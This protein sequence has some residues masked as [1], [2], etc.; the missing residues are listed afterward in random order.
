MLMSSIG[1]GFLLGTLLGVVKLIIKI[2]A[3]TIAYIWT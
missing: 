3:F 1:N 2:L